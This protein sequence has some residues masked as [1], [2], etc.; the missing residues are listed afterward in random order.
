MEL[1]WKFLKAN[2]EAKRLRKIEWMKKIEF[3]EYVDF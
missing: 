2:Y 3:S 1:V